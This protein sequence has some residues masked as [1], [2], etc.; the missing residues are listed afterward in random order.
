MIESQSEDGYRTVSVFLPF[1]GL[2]GSQDLARYVGPDKSS[3][4]TGQHGRDA[5]CLRQ[6][7]VFQVEASGF[8]GGVQV[9]RLPALSI[10]A[11]IH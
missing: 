6:A 4:H 10:A 8:Q 11:E 2:L 1:H 5:L 3:R 9:F 7:R